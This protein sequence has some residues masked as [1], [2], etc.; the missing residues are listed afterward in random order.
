MSSAS[1][2]PQFGKPSAGDPYAQPAPSPAPGIAGNDPFAQPAAGSPYAQ[3]GPGSPYTQPA[4]QAPAQS[5]GA[6]RPAPGTSLGDDISAGFGFA[7]NTLRTNAAAVVVPGIV[8]GIVMAVITGIAMAAMFGIM[9]AVFATISPGSEPDESV[10]LGG[11]LGA[12]AAFF[13]ILLLLVP[14]TVVWA[15]GVYRVGQS[16]LELRRPTVGQGFIGSGRV[17]LTFLLTGLIVLVGSLLFYIPGL[18]AALLLMFA[19]AAASRGAS[20][21][22]AMKESFALVK[23]NIGAAL[24][25]YLVLMAISYV[26]G[27]LVVT[28]VVSIPLGYLFTQ[29]MYER[30]SRRELPDPE[31]AR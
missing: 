11:M 16:I 18:V 22:E 24:V 8:Y 23:N 3:P 26:G 21:V 20:P 31:A 2:P 13:G 17:V 25:A 7:W 28:L 10:L 5:G 19:P 6:P 15:S 27:I 12:Y 9:A 30:L 29:G 4:Q 1:Q 14:V